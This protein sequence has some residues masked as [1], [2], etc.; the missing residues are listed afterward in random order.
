MEV[1]I[2]AAL[3]GAIGG[4]LRATI[5]ILK[6][7]KEG[8]KLTLPYYLTTPLLALIIGIITGILFDNNYKY[9][10]LA[11]YAGTDILEGITKTIKKKIS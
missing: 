11:G 7:I 10:I 4:M 5:G 1:I 2:I 6:A 3:L 9:S 8:K